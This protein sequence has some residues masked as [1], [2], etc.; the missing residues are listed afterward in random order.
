MENTKLIEKQKELIKYLDGACNSLFL[1]SDVDRTIHDKKRDK[2]E[3]E[4]AVLESAE[5]SKTAEL[6]SAE[7]PSDVVSKMQHEFQPTTETSFKQ[8]M[9]SGY[10]FGLQDGFKFAQS[11]QVPETT[12]K[13]A[14]EIKTAILF[15]IE[16]PDQ[17]DFVNRV[18]HLTN[19]EGD[20]NSIESAGYWRDQKKIVDDH[21][22]HLEEFASQSVP[23]EIT[24]EMKEELIK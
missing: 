22:I 11:R 15:I 19:Q 9:Y 17:D 12:G 24:D 7:I 8:G 3:S 2:L 5:K 1:I 10:A 4:L 21:L 13:S 6:M 23:V 14:E 16:N 20:D 18:Y